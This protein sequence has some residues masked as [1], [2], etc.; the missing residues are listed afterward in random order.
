MGKKKAQ[1]WKSLFSAKKSPGVLAKTYMSNSFG[2]SRQKYRF[3]MPWD[4]WADV[5]QLLSLRTRAPCAAMRTHRHEKPT[6]CNLRVAPNFHNLRKATC[7]TRDPAQ[8]KINKLIKKQDTQQSCLAWPLWHT[9]GQ[10]HCLC[11]INANVTWR[12]G[13]ECAGSITT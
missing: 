4:G 6:H 5:L 1:W 11:T 8:P 12:E 7:I 10:P 13:R 3:Y 2:E 9:F